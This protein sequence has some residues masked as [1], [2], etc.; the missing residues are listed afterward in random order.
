R[1]TGMTLG[2][3]GLTII[4]AGSEGLGTEAVLGL[5]AVFVSTLIHSIST[6]MVKKSGTQIPAL[7]TTTGALL[8]AVPCYFVSW[9]IFDG[10]WPQQMPS[11]AVAAIIY[12]GI[13][14]TALGFIFYFHA[15]RYVEASR[16]AM[17]PL[18]T[19]VLALMAGSYFNAEPITTD[20]IMGTVMILSGLFFYEWRTLAIRIR[21]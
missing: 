20:V 5:S 11:H 9:W 18:M 19:P 21:P 8:F 17:I 16:M 7:A 2:V 14:G 4:F 13:F 12:L 15:L 1:I 10:T 6:V 3:G